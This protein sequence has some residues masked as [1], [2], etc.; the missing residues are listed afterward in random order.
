MDVHDRHDEGAGPAAVPETGDPTD[1]TG[2][3]PRRRAAWA[4]LGGVLTVVVVV[5]LVAGYFVRLPYVILT[6]GDV[7]PLGAE[8]MTVDGATTYD[9][10]G[11]LLFLTVSVTRQRPNVYRYL[12]ERFTSP[13]EIMKEGEY[14]GEEPTSDHIR[15]DVMLM[16]QSQIAAR[17]VALEALGYDLEIQQVGVLVYGIFP[18][19]AAKGN[20]HLGDVITEV[21]G[22]PTPTATVLRDAIRAHD[23][24][25]E[26]VVTVD[27]A[28][29]DGGE[30]ESSEIGVTLGEEQ[31][32][33]VLGVMLQNYVQVSDWPVEI[34]LDT[35]RVTGSSAGLAFALAIMDLLSPGDLTG[36]QIVAITGTLS[37]DGSV[38][39]V[40]GV[41]LKAEA[42]RRAGA[43]LLI[44][45]K[46]TV[47]DAERGAG[48]VPVV[49]VDTIEEA[50]AALAAIGGEIPSSASD[51][52]LAA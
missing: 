9:S 48:S 4:W 45:P 12:R 34:E 7:Y 33:P 52:D 28:V 38:G 35:Q 24:G 46:S 10:D 47:E 32:I 31:G 27:R 25:D 43:A 42:A 51:L 21:D 19:H 1:G 22:Q 20:L 15:R 23:V 13:N 11:E 30:V 44:V 50:L 36:G 37:L 2:G 49:G 16:E 14:Y 40:G 26:I 3:S 29:G 8:T 17:A 18:E 5:A 39:R 41:E 6:P